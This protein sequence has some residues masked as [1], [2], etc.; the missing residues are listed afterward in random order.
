[1]AQ[2]LTPLLRP[3]PR[4]ALYP[5]A[6]Q[7]GSHGR[8]RELSSHRQLAGRTVRH[9]LLP[10]TWRP[11]VTS[12]S[13]VGGSSSGRFETNEKRAGTSSTHCGLLGP[14]HALLSHAPAGK[15]AGWANH[16]H[17]RG[18]RASAQ[19]RARGGSA[20]AFQEGGESIP[21]SSGGAPAGTAAE[22]SGAIR[23][24][25]GGRVVGAR[26]AA[27]DVPQDRQLALREA[28]SSSLPG[29][30]TQSYVVAPNGALHGP[31]EASDPSRSDS[32][33]A[34]VEAL[35]SSGSS[36]EATAADVEP[37]VPCFNDV[38]NWFSASLILLIALADG[39]LPKL[40]LPP[41]LALLLLAAVQWGLFVIPTFSYC[42]HSKFDLRSTFLLYRSR[43]RY[44][45]AAAIGGASVWVLLTATIWQRLWTFSASLPAPLPNKTVL[46]SMYQHYPST[47]PG[48]AFLIAFAA[49]SPA[50]A[51]ELLFRG[52]LLTALKPH[53][54]RFDAIT[55]AGALFGMFHLNLPQFFAT[56]VLGIASGLLA[57]CSGSIITPIVLHAVH[58]V[59]ALAYGGMTHAGATLAAEGRVQHLPPWLVVAACFGVLIA[60]AL[61]ASAWRE[62]SNG[63]FWRGGVRGS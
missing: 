34:A 8:A 15:A 38:I 55:M 54:G 49:L 17:P 31:R 45:L 24:P 60:G 21:S 2:V 61:M 13:E 27:A 59:A 63:S 16:T 43:V 33:S 62:D 37:A 40:V 41:S 57:T 11:P 14:V 25:P 4:H 19:H 18:S 35:S 20:G 7:D 28:G 36:G 12:Q 23:G 26:D 50:I 53:L 3:S 1:M 48:W 9:S 44:M 6:R 52:F 58:N 56:T 47:R 42:L 32:R 10:G 46:V 39:P 29:E 22:R 51:A 5:L 30:T